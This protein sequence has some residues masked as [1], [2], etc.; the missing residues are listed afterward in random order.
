MNL[1]SQFA[2]KGIEGVRFSGGGATGL[3]EGE[4]KGFA[5]RGNLEDGLTSAMVTAS[6]SNNPATITPAP[7]AKV[8]VSPKPTNNPRPAGP[9][10]SL[11]GPGL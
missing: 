9:G 1:I 3:T 4:L 7:D 10:V 8:V 6:I 2:S 5:S 11:G